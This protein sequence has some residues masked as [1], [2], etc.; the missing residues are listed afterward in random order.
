M[1]RTYPFTQYAGETDIVANV[2][3][4]N[5]TMSNAQNGARIKVLGGSPFARPTPF[6]LYLMMSVNNVVLDSTAG[7]GT[8][9]VNNV[10]FENFHGRLPS[11]SRETSL[12]WES[13]RPWQ[14]RM[15]TTRF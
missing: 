15:S 9:F 13:A 3:V 12:W 5:I 6:T 14:F 4:A 10:T 8:G 7:G 11:R 2:T 1:I